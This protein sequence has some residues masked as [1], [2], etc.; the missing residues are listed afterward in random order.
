MPNRNTPLHNA[1]CNMKA[2][3]KGRHNGSQSYPERGIGY[4]LAWHTFEGF[5][6][7]MKD[8]WKPGLTLERKDNSKGYSKDN[9][10]WATRSQQQRNTRKTKLSIDKVRAIKE[11][12]ISTRNLGAIANKLDVSYQNVYDV[13]VRGRWSE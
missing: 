6:A 13:I 1:W 12:Y 10:I 7:D 11:L 4:D 2:R 9:C 3:C 5:L 8:S